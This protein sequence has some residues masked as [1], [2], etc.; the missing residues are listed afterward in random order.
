VNYPSTNARALELWHQEGLNDPVE[1][2][3]RLTLEADD[4]EIAA[5]APA[6]AEPIPG[7]EVPDDSAAASGAGATAAPVEPEQ[8][9]GI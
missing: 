5:G 3:E 6:H 1:I 9:G 7:W 8:P 2:L 4:P